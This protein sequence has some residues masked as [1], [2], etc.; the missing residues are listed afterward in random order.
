[1]FDT[2]DCKTALMAVTAILVLA[3]IYVMCTENVPSIDDTVGAAKEL[4]KKSVDIATDGMKNVKKSTGKKQVSEKKQ[5]L[6]PRPISMDYF[7]WK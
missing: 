5:K 3:I 1:M 2:S 4:A 6:P 7:N